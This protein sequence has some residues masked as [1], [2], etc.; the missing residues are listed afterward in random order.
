MRAYWALTKNTQL[1]TQYAANATLNIATLQAGIASDRS[2]DGDSDALTVWQGY[3]CDLHAM[4]TKDLQQSPATFPVAP[5][6]A[7]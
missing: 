6:S 4:T 3:L 1:R 7:F 2:A 5:A